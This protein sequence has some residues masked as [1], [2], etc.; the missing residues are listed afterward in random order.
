MV[1]KES[2]E[3]ILRRGQSALASLYRRE[4]TRAAVTE[5]LSESGVSRPEAEWLVSETITRRQWEAGSTQRRPGQGR[6]RSHTVEEWTS[7]WAEES[8]P[9]CVKPGARVTRSSSLAASVSRIRETD[10]SQPSRA[11]VYRH[12]GDVQGALKRTDMCRICEHLARKRAKE[13]A[14]PEIAN[15]PAD[16]VE[17]KLVRG[18]EQN[19]L[20]EK[21]EVAAEWRLL[22]WHEDVARRQ[23]S[24]YAQMAKDGSVTT[25]LHDFAANL[26]VRSQREE[27]AGWRAPLTIA[28]WMAVVIKYEGQVPKKRRFVKFLWDK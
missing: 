10:P 23:Q 3:F 6:K 11:S 13:S 2:E 26:Q 19:L 21:P 16:K 9:T 24:E 20:L 15:L 18:H 7:L 4:A 5:A 28:Y 14:D 27:S 25:V 8:Y 22:L 1:G 17:Q 12:R